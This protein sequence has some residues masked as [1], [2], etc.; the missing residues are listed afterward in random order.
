M[1]EQNPLFCVVRKHN[2]R[3][4][5][6]HVYTCTYTCEKVGFTG[7]WQRGNRFSKCD[8]HRNRTVPDRTHRIAAYDTPR[9][10]L[11]VRLWFALG[12]LSV[13]YG[14]GAVLKLLLSGTVGIIKPICAHRLH[15]TSRTCI[16][17][18]YS[19]SLHS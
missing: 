1:K 10:S 16:L 2:L 13:R 6:C 11:V 17:P 18:H 8:M 9:G 19:Y 5:L 7:A 4:T 14:Y 15:H 3:S 12:T